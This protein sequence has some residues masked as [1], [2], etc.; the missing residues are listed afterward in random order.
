MNRRFPKAEHLCSRRLMERLHAEGHRL[1][2]FPYSVQWIEEPS[3]EVSCQVLIV[4]PK[5]R[6]HHAVDRNRIK[7]LTRECYRL[8]KEAIF[9]ILQECDMHITLS[10]VYIHDDLMTYEQ[11]K[12]KFDKLMEA[13][14]NELLHE[15]TLPSARMAVE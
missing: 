6:L 15:K 14:Q 13:L 5:R 8:H 3:L 4:V 10:L 1:R 11:L 9:Q 12:H 2:V 7:R